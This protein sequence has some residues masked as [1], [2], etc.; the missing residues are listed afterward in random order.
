M[1]IQVIRSRYETDTSRSRKEYTA[2][3]GTQP[4]RGGWGGFVEIRFTTNPEGVRKQS[5]DVQIGPED[6]KDLA[7]AMMLADAQA[8][9]KGFGVAMQD[10]PEIPRPASKKSIS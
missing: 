5:F 10:V 4:R 3:I 9:I 1:P 2:G 8:A 7:Q 6:F